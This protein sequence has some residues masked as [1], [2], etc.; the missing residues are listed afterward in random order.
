MQSAMNY[1]KT[2]DI[3]D[4]SLIRHDACQ[5]L[6]ATVDGDRIWFRFPLFLDI[7]PRA[8]IF[9]SL[10]MVEGMV[11]GIPVRIKDD[12]AISNRLAHT[13]EEIQ[14]LLKSWNDD[15]VISPIIAKTTK[16]F[17][18]SQN[19]ISCFSGGI[20]STY[21][22]GLYRDDITHILLM[23]CF[24]DWNEEGS[25]EQNVANR[26][27]FADAQ[28]IKLI[29][30]ET[31]IRYIGNKRKLDF[32]LLHGSIVAAV[33]IAMN[34][35]IFLMP[36]SFSYTT[37]HPWG[38]HPL[39]DPLWRTEN[40]EIIHHGCGV[41]RC[42]K[43]KYIAQEQKFLDQIQVCW[44]SSSTN[45]GKCSK[46]LRTA[47]ALK[48]LGKKCAILPEAN[49][50]EQYSMMA[51]EDD[52]TSSFAIELIDLCK[53]YGEVEIQK[54]IEKN[55]KTYKIK[56]ATH[57]FFKAL[58]GNPGRRLI[59]RFSNSSWYKERAT[60]TSNKVDKKVR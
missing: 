48:I 16:D 36:S 12:I 54:Y 29:T 34:P 19:V 20:D 50:K 57:D 7:E 53:E 55:L 59:R 3:E 51:I 33:G 22:Y 4:I 21:T 37:L 35:K 45:C 39:L 17:P 49:S 18:Q 47:I 40:T 11:R 46:C 9:M 24:D 58:A 27:A 1:D 25:W 26:Q 2:I 43:T 30:V 6:S 13:Y 8:E 23:D 60:V 44:E 14:A 15:F 10:A 28:D 31:N 5:E 41:S 42:E 38:S 56:S 52:N 32:G